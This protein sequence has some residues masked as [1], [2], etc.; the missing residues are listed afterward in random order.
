MK[1]II[2][3]TIIS[4]GGGMQV[5]LSF[6]N[7]LKN[8]GNDEYHVFLS[9]SVGLHLNKEYFPANFNFY[10]FDQSPAHFISR[11]KVVKKLNMLV[12]TI[13][14]D[15]IFSVF[16][17]TYWRPNCTHVMGFAIPHIIY[18]D[19]CAVKNLNFKSKLEFKY[20]KFELK[21]NADY[22]ITE[23]EDASLRLRNILN[24]K[25]QKVFTVNNT[26]SDCFND[27]LKESKRY[28]NAYTL[29]TIANNTPHKNLKIIPRVI[30]ELKRKSIQVTFVIT[31]PNDDYKII[32]YG[33]EKNVIN[34]GTIKPEECPK[35]YAKCDAMF[36]PTLLEVFSASYPEA[37]KM[38][39][40]ILTSNLG[41]A[42]SI[43]KDAALYFD[44]VNPKDIASKIELL[45]KDK[46]IQE[47]LI[48]KGEKRLL[49]FPNSRQ[50][51]EKYI[52]ICKK[53]N[54]NYVQE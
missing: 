27:K 12:E 54:K 15:V 7:E 52:A 21:N 45:V 35:V 11:K 34:I 47:N 49:D 14:P 46:K 16:G 18:D 4:G 20:K 30:D 25:K 26:Y 5:S 43:C 41:F 37:M 8:F 9:E 42:K 31:I 2:N 6:L 44:P 39:K 10:V 13:E 28:S 40:P 32:F 19:Y 1:I 53:I 36:L 29:L 48:L 3:T 33:Y 22:Y 24:D 38:R 50:R 17:P 23:S 51:A